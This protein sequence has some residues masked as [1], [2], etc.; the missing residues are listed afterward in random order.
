MGRKKRLLVALIQTLLIL[1]LSGSVSGLLAEEMTREQ[2]NEWWLTMYPEGGFAEGSVVD[3]PR[4]SRFSTL[5][6]ELLAK[7]APDEC[8][9]GLG[10]PG[11]SYDPDLSVPCSSGVP[12]VNQSYV[13]GLAKSSDDLWF[14]T[15]P[16][17]H[18]M[19]LGG[20]LGMTGPQENSS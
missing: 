20:Y 11:N 12:K 19:V 10:D 17:V 14:G 15:A 16:N 7:A 13:W 5:A 2:M 1:F 6:R 8:F 4:G 9:Q 18:C 3:D